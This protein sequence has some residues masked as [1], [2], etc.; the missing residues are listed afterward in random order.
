MR[1]L[2]LGI[3]VRSPSVL[4]SLRLES[5]GRFTAELIG[6]EWTLTGSRAHPMACDRK[7]PH[8]CKRS[9]AS[10]IQILTEGISSEWDGCKT[11]GTGR[12][13]SLLCLFLRMTGGKYLCPPTPP[14]TQRIKQVKGSEIGFLAVMRRFL[15]SG[16]KINLQRSPAF[17]CFPHSGGVPFLTAVLMAF[18]TKLLFLIVRAI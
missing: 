17:I 9:T 7:L 6:T 2:W 12:A 15:R 13:A 10:Q 18:R 5:C 14:P 16:T 1:E 4:S 8:G 11:A 3:V